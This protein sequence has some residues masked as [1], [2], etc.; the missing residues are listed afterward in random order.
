MEFV[1][2]GVAA[3]VVVVLEDQHPTGAAVARAIE[4]RRREPADAPPDDDQ[5]IGLTRIDGARHGGAI[6]QCVRRLECARVAA[7]HAGEQRRIIAGKI[8]RGAFRRGGLRAVGAQQRA[9]QGAGGSSQRA[10]QEITPRDAALRAEPP[11]HPQ[12]PRT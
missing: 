6:G 3:E 9:R 1:A 2:L 8:L 12:P 10:L 7:A 11:I 5:I 4:V